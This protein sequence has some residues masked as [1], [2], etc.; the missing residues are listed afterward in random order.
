[1]R[2]EPFKPFSS[3]NNFIPIGKIMSSILPQDS[4]AEK[5]IVEM[6]DNEPRISHI[7]IAEQTSNLEVSVRNLI[8]KYRDNFKDFGVVL[9]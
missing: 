8:N 6:I 5:S 7:V 2:R 4:S 1:L 9:K 3:Q